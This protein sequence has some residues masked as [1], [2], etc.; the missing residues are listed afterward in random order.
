MGV[1]CKILFY[2]PW[3]LFYNE[4]VARGYAFKRGISMKWENS[5]TRQVAMTVFDLFDLQDHPWVDS[6]SNSE[7]A[8]Y[9][10]LVAKQIVTT[11]GDDLS[12]VNWSQ[13]A[14]H[15]TQSQGEMQ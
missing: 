9:L 11:A 5:Q 1:Y 4:R 14:N 6:S 10:W 8:N 13:I 12:A 15:L 2:F 3:F 7:V